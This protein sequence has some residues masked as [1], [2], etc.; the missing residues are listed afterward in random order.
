M[1]NILILL[2]VLT[3]LLGV[4]HFV[5]S[6]NSNTTLDKEAYHFEVA[7][8]ESVHEISIVERS[9]PPT[10]LTRNGNQW[11]LNDTYI[12]RENA[13]KNLLEVIQNVK[14]DYLPTP[15]AF[16]NIM[17]DMATL[18]IR[19]QVK[20]KNKEVLQDYYI[21]GVTQGETGTYMVKA[22]SDRPFIMVIPG[23]E[24]SF[25]GRF[26]MS[27]EDWRDRTVLKEDPDQIKHLKVTY[28]KD[29]AESFELIK[30]PDG[31][32]I[33][34]DNKKLDNLDKKSNQKIEAY[35]DGYSLGV[36]EYIENQNEHRDSIMT[37]LPFCSIN[38]S[39]EDGSE[40]SLRFFPVADMIASNKNLSD[41]KSAEHITRYFVDVDGT[42]FML[43]QQRLF[44]KL[45]RGF[46]YFV[47]E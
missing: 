46:S 34:K 25:R 41:L 22:E 31:Y 27:P 40:K 42:D 16:A 3:L 4:W 7:D 6:E 18:G 2:A 44:G 35:L 9:K 13:I 17:R 39:R 24:G 23:L 21:G 14:V 38:I 37:L 1:K 47:T 45:F 15:E 10:K 8:I 30:T 28:P 26:I 12:A 43:V 11:I 5:S 32:E 19:V 36:A 20:N 29:I 33:V